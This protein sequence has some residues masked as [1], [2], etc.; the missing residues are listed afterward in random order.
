VTKVHYQQDN[1]HRRYTR[2][3]GFGGLVKFRADSGNRRQ[4]DW[5]SPTVLLQQRPDL[6]ERTLD[7]NG[8]FAKTLNDP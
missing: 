7:P 2:A 8:R 1:N 6:A 3:V 4:I 5:R